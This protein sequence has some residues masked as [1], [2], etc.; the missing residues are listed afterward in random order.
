VYFYGEEGE[1]NILVLEFLGPNIEDLFQYTN[2]K[3]SKKTVLML[4]DQ[5]V[6]RNKLEK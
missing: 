3:F 5:I 6:R 4:A 2:Q 1:Y